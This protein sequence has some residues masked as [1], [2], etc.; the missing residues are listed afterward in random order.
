MPKLFAVSS[1]LFRA[2]C[3]ANFP[4]KKINFPISITQRTAWHVRN[5]RLAIPHKLLKWLIKWSCFSRISLRRSWRGE[6]QSKSSLT[7]PWYY[8]CYG[9]IKLLRKTGERIAFQ[10]WNI[11]EFIS[12]NISLF[13]SEEK[14]CSRKYISS[15]LHFFTFLHYLQ[16][17][18]TG[19]FSSFS[20]SRLYQKSTVINAV[21]NT[22]EWMWIGSMQTYIW[23]R[24][25]GRAR[26]LDIPT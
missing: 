22:R 9:Y 25:N 11:S 1:R 14:V 15:Y 20:L 24:R 4:R 16:F 18:V 2:A 19:D 23:R 5:I 21:V 3:L 6:T 13:Q 7:R 26:I 8:S 10:H 12:Y 17:V